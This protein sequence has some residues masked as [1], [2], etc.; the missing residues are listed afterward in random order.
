MEN[1]G[2]FRP[3]PS[4]P[5]GTAT[6]CCTDTSRPA[7]GANGIPLDPLPLTPR[8][9]YVAPE[10]ILGARG[11]AAAAAAGTRRRRPPPTCS[12]SG[13]YVRTADGKKWLEIPDQAQTVGEYEGESQTRGVA[14]A[15]PPWTR[16]RR[17]GCARRIRGPVARPCA[18]AFAASQYFANDPGLAALAQLDRFLEL[19]VLARAA[20]L[21]S[22]QGRWDLFDSRVLVTRVL[23]PLLVELRTPQLQPLVLPIILQLCERQTPGDFTNYTLPY[24]AP[25]LESASGATLGTVL[26]SPRVCVCREGDLRGGVRGC[27]YYPRCSAASTRRR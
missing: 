1:R 21:Q 22:L 13:R 26:R 23:P 3:R 7:L 17:R 14:R 16:R 5:T 24:L 18:G 15:A 4:P 2:G 25:L 9:A 10:L 6:A 20:F 12:P 19:D 27:A 8:L 11:R